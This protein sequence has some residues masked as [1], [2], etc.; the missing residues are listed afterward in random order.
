MTSLVPKYGTYNDHLETTRLL[1]DSVK[2][3]TEADEIGSATV[4]ELQAQGGILKESQGYVSSMRELTADA[5]DSIKGM[6]MKAR[7]KKMY[8]YFAMISLAI[9]NIYVIVRLVHNKGSLFA[10]DDVVDASYDADTYEK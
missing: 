8:L 10:P 6:W 4:G 3:A 5:K 2:L 9:A 7:R 1:A